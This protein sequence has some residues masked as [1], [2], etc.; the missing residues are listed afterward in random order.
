MHLIEATVLL[1]LIQV[2]LSLVSFKRIVKVLGIHMSHSDDFSLLGYDKLPI[3][4]L[5]SKCVKI[6]SRNL[7][8]E[9]KCLAQATVLKLMLQRRGVQ[10]TLYLGVAINDKFKA[11]AWLLVGDTVV[12]GNNSLHEYSVVSFFS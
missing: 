7:P 12:I 11:H 8:W 4:L 9:C 5:A 2:A 1:A 3:I 10:S 6:M